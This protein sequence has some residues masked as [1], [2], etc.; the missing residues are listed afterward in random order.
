MAGIP[1]ELSRLR[2]DHAVDVRCKTDGGVQQ[3]AL[4]RSLPVGHRRFDQVPGH[5]ELVVVPQIRPSA[6]EAPDDVVGI[7]IP[8]RLLGGHDG[9]DRPVRQGFQRRIGL[10]AQTEGH[11]LQP[12]ISV[13]VLERVT[14]EVSRFQPCRDAEIAHAAAF[15]R[16]FRQG[17]VQSRPLIRDGL[18]DQGVPE[19]S[20]KAVPD[21]RHGDRRAVF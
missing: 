8:V 6:I 11:P 10:P 13:A 14:V 15:C 7:Q 3:D 16:R 17:V 19:A 12:F 20:P 21:V 18:P 2:P 4:S 9:L 1:A 5:I